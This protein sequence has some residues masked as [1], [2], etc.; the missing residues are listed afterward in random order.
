MVYKCNIKFSYLCQM[1]DFFLKNCNNYGR[2]IKVIPFADNNP[3]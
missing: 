1:K 2:N 3:D